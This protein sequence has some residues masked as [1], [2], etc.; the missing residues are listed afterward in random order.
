MLKVA[1]AARVR[2]IDFDSMAKL[3][4]FVVKLVQVEYY[5]VVS[6]RAGQ[7]D[8]RA[9]RRVARGC[10]EVCR[11]VCNMGSTMTVPLK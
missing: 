10:E 2:F 8:Q 6:M 9:M 3:N 4:V 7:C 1:A 11:Y 5:S